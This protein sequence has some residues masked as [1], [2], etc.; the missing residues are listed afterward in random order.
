[1]PSSLRYASESAVMYRRISSTSCDDAIS[2]L[3]VGVSMP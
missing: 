3:R 2:S 1:M